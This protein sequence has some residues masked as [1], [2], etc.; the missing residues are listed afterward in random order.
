VEAELPRILGK[1]LESPVVIFYACATAD[2]LRIALAGKRDGLL[3]LQEL[4]KHP[5]NLLRGAAHAV[6]LATGRPPNKDAADL[7]VGTD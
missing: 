2:G 7:D 6:Q 3:A 4:R 1:V 5:K